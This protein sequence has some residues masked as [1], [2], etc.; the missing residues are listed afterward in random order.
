MK[1]CKK[2]SFVF[3]YVCDTSLF[4]SSG[5]GIAHKRKFFHGGRLFQCRCSL[6]SV[7][8]ICQRWCPFV[9]GG[10]HLSTMVSICQQWCPFVNNGVHL[11]TVVSIVSA[12]PK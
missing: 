6:S 4:F 9:N 10:V 8:S 11:S 3:V 12:F 7:M 5:L 1:I 2:I